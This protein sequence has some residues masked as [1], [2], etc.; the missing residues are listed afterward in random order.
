MSSGK[1]TKL[2]TV[3]EVKELCEGIDFDN[4]PLPLIVDKILDYIEKCPDDAD[5]HIEVSQDLWR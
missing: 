5:V 3:R 4:A 1:Y 2:G